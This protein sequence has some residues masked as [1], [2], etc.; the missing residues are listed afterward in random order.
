M[1]SNPLRR[2]RG[3]HDEE[4]A[5]DESRADRPGPRNVAAV[6]NDGPDEGSDAADLAHGKSAEHGHTSGVEGQ[7]SGEDDVCEAEP[8]A[9]ERKKH[10]QQHREGGGGDRYRPRA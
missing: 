9:G 5:D 4:S 10:N 8:A 1:Q 6:L 7:A 3:D 2:Q